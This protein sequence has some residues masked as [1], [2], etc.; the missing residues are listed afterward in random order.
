MQCRSL[1]R[2]ILRDPRARLP[3][4]AKSQFRRVRAGGPVRP[5]QESPGWGL[6]APRAAGRAWYATAMAAPPTPPDP[7]ELAARLA[8]IA[9]VGRRTRKP[10]PRWLW[11]CAGVVGVLCAIGFV[12]GLATAP[13]PR[14]PH[15]VTG[16]QTG[17][18]LGT[19]LAIGAGVGIVIGF[20]IARQRPDH[21]SRNSP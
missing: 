4:N 16:S 18:G 1:S 9:D 8:S 21:S 10:T 12:V 17:S 6:E 19:G 14:T 3:E 7:A 5:G 11:V 13:A 2:N 20:V 15:P